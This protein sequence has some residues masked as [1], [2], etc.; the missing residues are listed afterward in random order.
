M[1]YNFT[2]EDIK[3]VMGE[4]SILIKGARLQQVFQPITEEIY[5]ELYVSKIT[6]YLLISI[7]NGFNRI[8]LVRDKPAN[9][10]K[11]PHSFQMLLRKYIVPS[12]IYEISQINDD[13]VIMISLG[14]FK[15]FAELTGRHS[16]IFLVDSNDIILG[17]LK[18]N[19]SQKRPLFVSYKY[20]P[21]FPKESSLP[22]KIMIQNDSNISECYA[23]YY[24]KLINKYR[25]NKARR[26]VIK[27][28]NNQERH[29][30]SVLK[31]IENDK[32]N[33]MKYETYLMYAEALKQN[34]II[35]MTKDSVLCEYY[36]KSGLQSITVP[37]ISG[38]DITRNMERYFKL[39][40]KY[41]HSISIIER[42][43]NEIKK[44]YEDV[45]KRKLLAETSDDISYLRS[46]CKFKSDEEK[47]DSYF[48]QYRD[49]KYPFKVFFLEGVG[50][51]YSGSN[52]EENEILTF[53]F[54]RGNDLW[55][56]VIGY[57]GSHTILPSQNN[58]VHSEKQIITAALLCAARS[59]APDGE[60]VEV[61]YT[62]V[63]Y[64][65][66]AKGGVKGAVIFSN[67][68][69]ILVKVNKKFPSTLILL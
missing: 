49:K 8:Y 26:E 43:E 55:F 35:S 14:E 21:P 69:R 60:S 64:V 11:N 20:I 12:Y 41:K 30:L 24:E 44:S 62:K 50:R 34:R 59:S 17:S 25:I 53:K 28:L 13:R 56:H 6:E 57:S 68:K 47:K 67:E 36:T 48:E 52:A 37:L 54:A 16:N 63:K 10:P 42:R 31:K 9:M 46:L 33:A 45:I 66:K 22:S 40:K 18:E 15:I 7:E 23:R 3:K 32:N 1:G 29:L 27:E 4:L 2:S 39:Y 5:F 19:T 65:R 38:L 58:K 51:I 61:A